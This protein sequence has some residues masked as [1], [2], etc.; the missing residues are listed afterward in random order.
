MQRTRRQSAKAPLGDSWVVENNSEDEEDDDDELTPEEHVYPAQQ[1]LKVEEDIF[2]PPIQ[3]KSPR[4]KAAR[5]RSRP[6]TEPDLIMPSLQEANLDGSWLGAG[7]MS[8]ANRA[9]PAKRRA[10][11]QTPSR[12]AEGSK[13]TRR[14]TAPAREAEDSRSSSVIEVFLAITGSLWI[15]IRHSLDV[16]GDA[17]KWAKKP[18]AVLLSLFLIVWLSYMFMN[19]AFNHFK[20]QLSIFC[21]IPGIAQ[22][23]LCSAVKKT[24]PVEFDRLMEVQSQFEVVLED[25]TE[26][27]DLPLDMK[28]GEASIRDLRQ[29]VRFS[30]LHSK[31]ELGLEFDGFIE[32]ARMASYD[33]Q[34]FN[35]HVSRAV[36]NV[37]AS[38][39]Y[40]TRILS[41]LPPV[42]RT[43][44]LGSLN[45]FTTSADT[46]Q[47]QKA[48]TTQYISH[49]TFL[50][51][52]IERLVNTAQALLLLLQNLD[53]RL[54][55][56]HTLTTRDELHAS[57]SR[58]E[59]LADLWTFLGANRAALASQ[60]R[61]LALL[62]HV[63]AYRKTAWAHVSGAILKL[64]AMGAGLE[65]LRERVAA[66]GL[67]ADS[68]DV[69]LDVHLESI[70][71]G[72]ERLEAGREKA[73]SRQD[74]FLRRT[75]DRGQD[76]GDE[77][78]GRG[79]IR[80]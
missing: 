44:L 11:R 49:T 10:P 37:L 3:P 57:T 72:V 40:T 38:T 45:P 55:T 75:L 74:D 53:D 20:S 51:T 13:R 12:E 77:T 70:A 65:D 6:S 42:H 22:T 30:N 58:D 29:L 52:E 64:Q 5:A 62:Q 66:P 56:I 2:D 80:G 78:R 16:L 36:D 19:M 17:V 15:V 59:I 27:I 61:Q 14:T 8:S 67:L 46:I 7:S 9:Q 76:G 1:D 18:L 39:R 26:G 41:S 48:I 4:R 69:P 35:S 31:N 28:R 50:S 63:S 25:S 54:D 71:L 43:S 73:K 32:T 60:D 68:V 47:V 21:Y 34:K 23:P 79:S 24:G 33:L